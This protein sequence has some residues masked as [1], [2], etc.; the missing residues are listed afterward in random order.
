MSP[1]TLTFPWRSNHGAMRAANAV[2]AGN[3][4]ERRADNGKRRKVG[5][6][7]KTRPKAGAQ[8]ADLPAPEAA[9]MIRRR[10]A[11]RFRRRRKSGKAGHDVGLAAEEDAGVGLVEGSET[12]I[13]PFTL[14]RLPG[15]AAWRDAEI[16]R[17]GPRW[18]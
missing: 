2:G 3:N 14:L 4:T 8:E 18:R 13:R 1:G 6:A 12:R 10:G 9:W 7:L 15:E 16:E 5:I 11:R 17:A